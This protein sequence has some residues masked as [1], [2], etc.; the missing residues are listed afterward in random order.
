MKTDPDGPQ[1]DLRKDLVAHLGQRVTMVAGY[2]LPITTTSERLLWAIEVK[3]Q[4]AV[5]KAVEKCVNNDPT[6]KKRVIGGQDIW[7]IVEE[8]DKGMAPP[9]IDLPGM[10]PEKEGKKPDSEDE[11][12]EGHFLPHGAFTVAQG[13]LFI[14]S[15]LNFLVKTLKPIPA[16]SQLATQPEFLKVWNITFNQL[17]IKQQSA[18]SFSWSDRAIRRP[19]R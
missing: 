13:Q 7:E 9:T 16:A 2:Q 12:K 6:I 4:A 3:N 14:S 18:R 1:I 17:G 11:E 5:A 8:E 19:T 10:G 15:H